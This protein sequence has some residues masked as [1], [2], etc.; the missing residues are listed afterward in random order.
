[1]ENTT[2]FLLKEYEAARGEM[3]DAV[4]E[5]RTL[6]RYALLAVAAIWSWVVASPNLNTMR[7]SGYLPLSSCSS[8]SAR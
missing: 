5:T 1:M 4:K 6:E 2:D 8:R 3:A 7:L